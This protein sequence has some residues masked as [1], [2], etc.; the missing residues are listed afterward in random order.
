[1]KALDDDIMLQAVEDFVVKY[2][3]APTPEEVEGIA[4]FRTRG[5]ILRLTTA[6]SV[7]GYRYLNRAALRAHKVAQTH[8]DAVARYG[9]P[10]DKE[11]MVQMHSDELRALLDRAAR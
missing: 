8:A 1:M 9:Y 3:R 7:Y 11:R 10:E 2:R 5:P 4:D 6:L